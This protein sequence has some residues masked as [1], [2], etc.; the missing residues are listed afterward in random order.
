MSFCNAVD[1]VG[2]NM[3]AITDS[4]DLVHHYHREWNT[5]A[6]EI[7]KRKRETGSSRDLTTDDHR[8]SEFSSTVGDGVGESK[9][10]HKIPAGDGWFL[11][12][13]D[14][15][16]T[17]QEPKLETKLAL[18]CAMPQG[19][20]VTLDFLTRDKRTSAKHFVNLMKL[21]QVFLLR[22]RPCS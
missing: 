4:C 12:R 7:T 6:N 17:S 5:L 1:K 18:C 16:E 22:I 15:W 10:E 11:Q 3:F 19:T 20:A 9:Q 14:T 8:G 2:V 13:S 21:G